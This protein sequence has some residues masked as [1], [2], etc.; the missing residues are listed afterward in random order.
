MNKLESKVERDVHTWA[1]TLMGV[2]STKLVTPGETGW[3]DRIFWL[4]CYP[5]LIEFKQRGKR[6]EPKQGHVH[7]LLENLGYEVQV[8]DHVDTALRAIRSALIKRGVE[9]EWNGE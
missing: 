6:P 9:C 2:T 7:E 1:E 4:P 3:P 5:L 8:H